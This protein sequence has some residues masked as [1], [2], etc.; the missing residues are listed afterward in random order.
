M[1]D[2]AG[3]D[4]APGAKPGETR[5]GVRGPG[6]AFTVPRAGGKIRG[7]ALARGF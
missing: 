7:A 2:Q 1:P 3:H 5:P 6:G 4:D